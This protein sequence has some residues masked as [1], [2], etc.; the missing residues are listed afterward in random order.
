MIV[1]KGDMHK[2]TYEYSS[3][4]ANIV[5]ETNGLANSMQMFN[6]SNIIYNW[7]INHGWFY[8]L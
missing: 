5:I 1:Y 4:K 3:I 8:I 6:N 2:T 7:G